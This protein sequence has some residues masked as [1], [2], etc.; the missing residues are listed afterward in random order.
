[1]NG[2]IVKQANLTG[3]IDQIDLREIPSGIYF[4]KVTDINGTFTK[5]VIKE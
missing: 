1:V 2:S 4:L 5:K 3:T